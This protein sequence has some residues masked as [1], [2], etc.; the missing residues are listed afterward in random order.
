MIFVWIYV[1]ETQSQ[2]KNKNKRKRLA[3]D[4][5]VF[6]K[7]SSYEY[8]NIIVK[9]SIPYGQISTIFACA[10]QFYIAKLSSDPYLNPKLSSLLVK[11]HVT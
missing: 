9:L 10:L 4:H 5:A 8:R 1:S 11:N 2:N 7:Q 6:S 3:C